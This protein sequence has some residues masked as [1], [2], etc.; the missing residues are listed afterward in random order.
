MYKM[1]ACYKG[2]RSVEKSMPGLCAAGLGLGPAPGPDAG[3]SSP[4][5]A[6]TRAK[7]HPHTTAKL[8]SSLQR[9]LSFILLTGLCLSRMT[10]D[11]MALLTCSYHVL[12]AEGDDIP[13]KPCRNTYNVA[14]T[15]FIHPP[16]GYNSIICVWYV[17]I[18]K[19]LSLLFKSNIHLISFEQLICCLI[20]TKACEPKNKQH[21]SKHLF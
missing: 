16:C 12:P 13:L 3:F 20:L 19:N 9:S 7:S 14:K 17:Y 2:W 21:T 11:V 10:A 4:K 15:L 6:Q 18:K 8:M 5:G 1:A